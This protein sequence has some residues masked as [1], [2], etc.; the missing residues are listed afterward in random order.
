M[1]L[2]M[3]GPGLQ[4]DL[5]RLPDLFTMVGGG[6]FTVRS[7]QI[8]EQVQAWGGERTSA[9]VSERGGILFEERSLP[10]ILEGEGQAN[11]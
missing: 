2:Q 5:A 3:C 8:E 9:H 11:L 10:Q 6:P 1:N 7:C 4:R